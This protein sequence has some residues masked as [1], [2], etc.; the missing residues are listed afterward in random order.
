MS[1]FGVILLQPLIALTYLSLNLD[2]GSIIGWAM[3]A[4]LLLEVLQHLTRL[5]DVL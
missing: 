4:R 3:L 5:P 2:V 1:N